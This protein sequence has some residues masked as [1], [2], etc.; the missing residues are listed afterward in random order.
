MMLRNEMVIGSTVI[1]LKYFTERGTGL[2]EFY[3]SNFANFFILVQD[4]FIDF[5][6][7]AWSYGVEFASEDMDDIDIIMVCQG[8]ERFCYYKSCV[9]ETSMKVEKDEAILWQIFNRVV[10]HYIHCA[11]LAHRD[12]RWVLILLNFNII[13]ITVSLHRWLIAKGTISIYSWRIYTLF[14]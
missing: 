1:M 7:I 2:D 5:K 14:T 10:F 6:E 12:S 3:S 11:G 9:S 8:D 4:E 13:S